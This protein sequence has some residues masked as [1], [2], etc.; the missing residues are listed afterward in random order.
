MGQFYGEI[1]EFLRTWILQQKIFWVATAP[2]SGEGH[3]NLSP[4]GGL[5]TFHIVD[6]HTVWYE[7]VTGSG[8]RA[9]IERRQILDSIWV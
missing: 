9:V 5:G 2:L 3:V 6:K 7:D 8:K 1:P 4:K